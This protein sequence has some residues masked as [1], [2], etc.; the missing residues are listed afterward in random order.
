M[1]KRQ[2][3]IAIWCLGLCFT[4]WLFGPACLAPDHYLFAGWGD[5]LKNYFTFAWHVRNDQN[6]LWFGGMNAPWPEHVAFTDGHPLISALAG[7]IPFV[8]DH[9]VG[10][11][12]VLMMISFPLSM[13]LSFEALVSYRIRPWLACFFAAVLVLMQP[14]LFRLLGHLSL[15]YG[16]WVPLVFLLISPAFRSRYKGWWIALACALGAA[17]FIHPYV[18]VMSAFLLIMLGLLHAVFEGRSGRSLALRI[19]ASAILPVAAFMAFTAFTDNRT[20]RTP[21]TYGF[22]EYAASY[23]TVF[24]PHHPPL[25]HLISQIIPVHAQTW[26]GWAYIGAPSLLTLLVLIVLLVAQRSAC[27][28]ISRAL[29]WIFLASLPVLC[30]S[31]A[32]PFM[33][34]AEWLLDELP[35]VRQFRSPGRFAWIFYYATFFLVA[36]AFEAWWQKAP[37]RG[38]MKVRF[39][40]TILAALLYIAEARTALMEVRQALSGHLN[41]FRQE[42]LPKV[43]IQQADALRACS[44]STTAWLPLPFL[45]YG[46]DV[47]GRVPDASVQAWAM[48]MSWHSGVPMGAS[49]LSRTSLSESRAQ[50][51]RWNPLSGGRLQEDAGQVLLMR[52]KAMPPLP[53]DEDL[54]WRNAQVVNMQNAI[55]RPAY[56][57]P[58]SE[59][60]LATLS[61]FSWKQ[62]VSPDSLLY[63]ERDHYMIG[64]VA[65]VRQVVTTPESE[66][67]L[68]IGLEC[69][70]PWHLAFLRVIIEQTGS[71]APLWKALY[72]LSGSSGFHD[73]RVDD[74]IPVTPDPALG[75]VRIVLHYSGQMPI[76]FRWREASWKVEQQSH[77]N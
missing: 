37:G 71:G 11:L 28:G 30:F 3:R 38:G 66:V 24:V 50:L 60:W 40:L 75:D 52:P 49:A 31:F 6:W 53:W 76:R 41:L 39:L 55:R 58:K 57:P 63:M 16:W 36:S 64:F 54:V 59:A 7:W 27:S 51:S 68:R 74:L 46:S 43:L 44:D 26:E 14:Q 29:F 56:H 12:N 15:S 23:E 17:C 48:L 77:G 19:V 1:T 13:A 4:G 25:R 18:A 67:F 33:W 21:Y 73:N 72:P 47:Y 32:W 62:V 65:D 35:V 9:P 69:D 2:A 5:G 45:H 61:D 10:T 8:R 20:D 34:G 70:T 22:T 42:Y